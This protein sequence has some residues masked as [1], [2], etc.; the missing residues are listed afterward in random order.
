MSMDSNAQAELQWWNQNVTTVNGSAIN[1]PGSDLYITSETFKAG[2]GACCQGSTTNGRWSL[3]ESKQHINILELKAAFLG[4]KAI[5]KNQSNITVCLRMD[6]PTAVSHVNNKGGTH[7]TQLVSLTHKLWQWC[8]QRAILITAQYLPGK[9]KDVARIKRVLQLQGMANSST[10]DPAIHK[11]VQCRPICLLPTYASWK[12]DPGSTYTVAMTLDWST[13]NGYAFPPFALISVVLRKVYQD[14]ADLVLVAP[15]WQAQPW[16]PA[17]LNS[18]IKN[19]VM[20][21][22]SKH[23]QQ[24]MTTTARA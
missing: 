7:S 23:L 6:N 16:W 24:Q 13:P 1:P 2:W 22:N 4:T 5:L 20:I 18:L 12:P 3:L 11:K 10:S 17:L 9:L 19:P 21:P 15:V 8:I 14:K